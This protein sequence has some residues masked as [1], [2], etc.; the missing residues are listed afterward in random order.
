MQ[1]KQQTEEGALRKNEEVQAYMPQVPFPQ[2]LQKDKL[3][4]QYSR[5]L[6]MFKKI[7]VNIPF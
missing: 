7:E 4:E 3:E 5:C 6:N 1:Q 2:R